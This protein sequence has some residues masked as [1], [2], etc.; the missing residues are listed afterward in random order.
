MVSFKHNI[1]SLEDVLGECCLF[2]H[3]EVINFHEMGVG[4]PKEW[5][6]SH[7][8]PF[9]MEPFSWEEGLWHSGSLFIP[10]IANKWTIPR[11]QRKLWRQGCLTS[12]PGQISREP[13]TK[14][15]SDQS[16]W[17][18]GGCW[19]SCHESMVPPRKLASYEGQHLRSQIPFQLG[20]TWCPVDYISLS[21]SPGVLYLD[22]SKRIGET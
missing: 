10:S 4:A 2:S 9:N 11:G 3:S 8:D 21:Q 17:L 5:R 15:P 20:S 12:L 22:P 6:L 1:K 13:S 19:W 16:T 7:V 14:S 18:S